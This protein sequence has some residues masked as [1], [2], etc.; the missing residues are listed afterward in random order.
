[1]GVE[2]VQTPQ[3][4]EQDNDE[5]I[6]AKE[7]LRNSAERLRKVIKSL[8]ERDYG[9][10]V[11]VDDFEAKMLTPP[12]SNY[13]SVL[14]A[15]KVTVR[16]NKFATPK[17]VNVVAKMLPSEFFQDVFNSAVTF[18]KEVAAYEEILP[19]Y[20]MLQLENGIPKSK[21][22]NHFPRFF[23]ARIPDDL[24]TKAADDDAVILLENLVAAGY[25]CG[26]RWKGLDRAQ[27]EMTV[28]TLATFHGLGIALRK[29]KP[30]VF[31]K[32]VKKA[33]TFSHP[34][35]SIVRA[36]KNCKN[37][38]MENERLN[39]FYARIANA[40][41]NGVNTINTPPTN[42]FGTICHTDFSINNMLFRNDSEG[43]VEAVKFID[44]QTYSHL[45]PVRDLLYFLIASTAENVLICHFDHLVNMYHDR[46]VRTLEELNCDVGNFGRSHFLAECKE[47]VGAEALHCC[48]MVK[49]ILLPEAEAGIEGNGPEIQSV[50]YFDNL[51]FEA[52][53]QRLTIMFQSF[54]ERDW[55]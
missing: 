35:T 27:S 49:I 9:E 8:F 30:E 6:A 11:M 23:G 22:F 40:L 37:M 41:D 54:L 39:P 10:N 14:L 20:Q 28:R 52:Y 16:R 53:R 34:S 44:F 17:V 46:L 19:A 5:W 26:N 43:N 42:Q 4:S 32:F 7:I 18:P 3:E 24:K 21:V 25:K 45:S 51:D 38:V 33:V 47:W 50:D 1:M 48:L 2:R 36:A 12:G 31:A 29:K 15:V 55:I 13:G